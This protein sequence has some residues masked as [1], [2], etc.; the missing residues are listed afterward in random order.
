MEPSVKVRGYDHRA[1][2][3]IRDTPVRIPD[4]AHGEAAP[5][6][7]GA[8]AGAGDGVGEPRTPRSADGE[9]A[10]MSEDSDAASACTRERDWR[11]WYSRAYQA[12]AA[13]S[14]Q[15][16]LFVEPVVPVKRYT[17][18]RELPGATFEEMFQR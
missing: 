14:E 18:I 15:L 17:Q 12:W 1:R 16:N 9:R 6:D 7:R 5:S 13:R 2:G 10:G 8:L 11:Y 3:G 4:A